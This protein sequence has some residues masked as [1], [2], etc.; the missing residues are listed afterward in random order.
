MR[1]QL[2]RRIMAAR[3][4]GPAA[5]ERGTS[6]SRLVE[7]VASVFFILSFLRNFYSFFFE[8]RPRTSDNGLCWAGLVFHCYSSRAPL[9]STAAGRRPPT[10]APSPS[11]LAAG[12][13]LHPLSLPLPT[14]GSPR[15]PPSASAA[16][17]CRRR[18][19]SS[20]CSAR[21]TAPAGRWTAAAPTQGPSVPSSIFF[22]Q[23][24]YL[25]AR[26]SRLIPVVN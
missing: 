9:H 5:R 20:P 17:G 4:R 13:L 8:A 25:M 11:H 24:Q 22:S 1:T 7:R 19:R 23:S 14:Q 6:D 21:W 26:A 12:L 3:R 18:R 2:R 15:W 10:T 16:A